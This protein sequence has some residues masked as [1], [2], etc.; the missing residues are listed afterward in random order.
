[1]N[2]RASI[3]IPLLRQMDQWLEE[4]VRSAV[5]QSIPTDVV[6]VRSNLTPSSNL[7]TLERLQRQY[8]ALS[9]YCEPIA[10]NYAGA[11]NAGFMRARA[12]RVGLLLSDDWLDQ[13]AIEECIQESADIVSTG[14]IVYFPDGRINK[15]ASKTPSKIR[16]QSL[17][18]LEAKANYLEHFFYFD[19]RLS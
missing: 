13:K 6:V 8:N 17:P 9:V 4:C 7:S 5:E 18:T 12:D 3:V 19:G 16:F 14:N 11:I 1:M 15:A 2:Y 10:N